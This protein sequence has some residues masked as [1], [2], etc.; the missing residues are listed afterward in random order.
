MTIG[1]GDSTS[2]GTH[3]WWKS[4]GLPPVQD[5]QNTPEENLRVLLSN[6]PQ[7]QAA[8][9][10]A[11]VASAAGFI[12]IPNDPSINS[13]DFRAAIGED[14]AAS[15]KSAGTQG[16]V[17]GGTIPLMFIAG[18][19]DGV[20]EESAFTTFK[21][22]LVNITQ[23]MKT[24]QGPFLILQDIVAS[25]IPRR[26]RKERGDGADYFIGNYDVEHGVELF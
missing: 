17:S 2:V 1:V 4:T 6:T 12:G 26:S 10:T 19:A 5:N 18:I 13:T 3:G 24:L 20:S 16:V 23:S 7:F 22:L 9:G 25:G 15:I 8:T 21:Q 11:T 14:G